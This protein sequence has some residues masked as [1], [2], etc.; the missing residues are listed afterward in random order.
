MIFPTVKPGVHRVNNLPQLSTH[1]VPLIT[2]LTF[3]PI[4]QLP[5]CRIANLSNSSACGATFCPLFAA[6][7]AFAI[8]FT[9]D[10]QKKA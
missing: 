1:H 6:G 7:K 3:Y 2:L 9:D 4:N 8:T 10:F 5:N